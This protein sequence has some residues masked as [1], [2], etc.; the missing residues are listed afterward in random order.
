MEQIKRNLDK[1]EQRISAVCQKNG[2]N[3]DDITLIAVTKGASLE[4]IKAVWQL[5]Y[6]NF[7]E[8][9]LPHLKQAYDFIN[10]LAGGDSVKWDMIGHLQRNKVSA[11]LP[12]VSR[13]H[14]VDSLRLAAE[15]ERIAPKLG[16]KVDI[17]LQVNCSGEGQKYGI[18]PEMAV[19]FA[20]QVCEGFSALN[21]V[22]IMT[23][24]EYTNDV[25]KITRTFA[26]AKDIFEKIKSQG[27]APPFFN[28][29]SMGMTNDYEIA[30]ANGATDIRVGS[31]IFG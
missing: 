25:A 27:F 15:I 22:G 26:L 9:R 1:L 19:E 6:T 18:A 8:N 5:G 31:A 14:S 30:I 29:L 23:M 10:A 20:N 3:R 2:V 17:F 11:F 12:L 13:I 24:A 16:K 7:G 4:Q 28:R 21:V